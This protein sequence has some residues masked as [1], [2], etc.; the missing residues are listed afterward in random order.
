MRSGGEEARVGNVVRLAVSYLGRERGV[1][2]TVRLFLKDVAAG[3]GPGAESH[4]AAR[5]LAV[6]I[7][8]K[9]VN[10]QIAALQDAA[11]VL[12]EAEADA[13]VAHMTPAASKS[14]TPAQKRKLDDEADRR[15][16]HHAPADTSLV[17]LTTPQWEMLEWLGA[18]GHEEGRIVPG[19]RGSTAKV[20]REKLKP[21]LV[22][23]VPVGA[24][25]TSAAQRLTPAGKVR[26]AAG[27]GP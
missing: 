8:L 5:P 3:E 23:Y 20:L 16:E 9:L 6:S 24:W 13:L 11:A 18:P 25:Q 1:Q 27:R 22:E 2:P 26:L 7:A 14:E 19:T 12:A 4:A 21:A 15:F 17:K 10:E